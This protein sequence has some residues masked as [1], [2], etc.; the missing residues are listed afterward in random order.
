MR[1]KIFSLL[2]MLIAFL[3]VD[4]CPAGFAQPAERGHIM[5]HCWGGHAP[6]NHVTIKWGHPNKDACFSGFPFTINSGATNT[7]DFPIPT[8]ESEFE[9]QS[10]GGHATSYDI[11]VTFDHRPGNLTMG[12]HGGWLVPACTNG[13]AAVCMNCSKGFNNYGEGNMKVFL[14]HPAHHPNCGVISCK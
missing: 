11:T 3:A 8:G 6:D 5:V 14:E 12:Y 13:C 2:T 4:L 1:T 7:L 9:I 10:Q